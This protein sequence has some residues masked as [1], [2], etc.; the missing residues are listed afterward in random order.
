M[1][2]GTDSAHV[3]QCR[4]QADAAVPAHTEIADVIEENNARDAGGIRRLCE[5]AAYC[6]I[7][8]ARLVYDSRTKPIVTFPQD[9][10]LV[11]D[12]AA[13]EIRAAVDDH[14]SRFSARV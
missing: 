11:C 8:A 6:H 9:F 10:Q 13:A 1:L 14:A 2:S 12:A 3:R 5:Q 4:N 7:G